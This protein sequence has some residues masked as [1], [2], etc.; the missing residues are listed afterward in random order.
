MVTLDHL[1]ALLAASLAAWRVPAE[2]RR[3][4]DAVQVLACGQ[5]IRVARA[6]VGLPFRYTI[7]VGART[8]HASS[9][10]GLL[11]VVRGAVD[12]EHRPVRLRIATAPIV[13]S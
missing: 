4:D 3:R 5:D 9:I 6:A 1:H 11:R 7:T 2:T 10:A 13:A 8:R 12:P